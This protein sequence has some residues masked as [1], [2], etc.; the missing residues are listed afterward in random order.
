MILPVYAYGQAVLKRRAEDVDLADAELPTLLAN[1][2]ETM[3]NANGVGLA[4]PQI[5]RS[6][7]IFVIDTE[8][9]KKDAEPG[10]DVEDGIKIAFL[11]A[12]RLDETGEL[13]AYEEGCLSIPHIRGDVE[14]P[15]TITLRYCDA[16]GSEHTT[17]FT[18]MNARVVQHEYDHIEGKLFVEKLKPLKRQ[19]VNRK[20]EKIRKGQ[21]S[22][23]YRLK[24][25]HAR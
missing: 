22:A 14:R 18:G 24:F 15:E 1:M 2:W 16:D 11:N 7:R 19:L 20:L 9:L 23:D 13:W 25:A 5:G 10:E 21:V 12:E 4:A 6:E 17:T 8:Q 3:Y